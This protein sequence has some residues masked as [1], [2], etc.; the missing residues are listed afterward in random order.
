MTC[1]VPYFRNVLLGLV[2]VDSFTLRNSRLF[3]NGIL[4]S[5]DISKLSFSFESS[6][7]NTTFS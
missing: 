4:S 3:T 1:N 2:I 6:K 7:E 5:E